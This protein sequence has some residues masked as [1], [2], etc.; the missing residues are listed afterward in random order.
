MRF[1]P[2]A[3]DTVLI[4]LADLAATL[5]LFDAIEAAALPQ[6]AELI[7][8]ARTLMVRLHPGHPV[9]AALVRSLRA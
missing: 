4:E 9:D 2:V 3:P 8:A 7:P 5:A 6:V 1:L